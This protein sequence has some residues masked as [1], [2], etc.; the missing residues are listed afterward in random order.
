MRAGRD[1]GRLSALA[2]ALVATW[3][4]AAGATQV[5][6]AHGTSPAHRP[7]SDAAA[8]PLVT[9]APTTPSM[10]TAT[11]TS[12]GASTPAA[13]NDALGELG[14]MVPF[15]VA[16]TPA[17]ATRAAA[18]S[19]PALQ[20]TAGPTSPR[21]TAAPSHAATPTTKP[22]RKTKTQ[23]KP[24]P[25]S[26]T[27]PAPAPMNGVARVGSQLTLDGTPW[28]FTG[29]D[30]FGAT[31]YYS[32]NQ[33]CGSPVYDV[34]RM[35]T[36]LKPRSVV[37]VWAFQALAWNSKATPQHEDFG[38]IDRVVQA[39]DRHGVKLIMTLS[40][41][42]GTCDDG[43]WHDPAWYEGGYR[44]IRNDN[45]L[46]LEDR[47]FADYVTEIV[48][49]YRADPA[50]A[51]WEPVNEP[52]SSTCSGATGSGCFDS[53]KRSC[54]ANAGQILKGFY[55]AV[56]AQIRALE[57]GALISEGVAGGGQCG[58][59]SGQYD[60]VGN[61]DGVDL[62][63]YHDY[64]SEDQ[65]LPGGLADRIRQ[66]TTEIH[67]P[68]IVEEAGIGGGSS[69]CR[70]DTARASLVQAKVAALLSAGGVGWLPWWYA[71]S[72]SSCGEDFGPG[73]PLIAVLDSFGS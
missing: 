4:A 44:Q 43:A 50:I 3:V 65:A 42:S 25:A 30:A 46:G 54:P 57:P 62:L 22:K 15:G 45:G 33:G 11:P 21:S 48:T 72:P 26:T 5:A 35:L 18:T 58:T 56:G 9:P 53:S 17:P 27:T 64:G 73:D 8:L 49:R 7:A 1:G 67:K 29:F 52:E 38:A 31:T 55:D 13:V 47:S 14:E 41:Q 69:P 32:I 34:D 61:S 63:T 68:L 12:P 23:P 39:A 16:V 70:S 28:T 6:G 10:P 40:D 71:E 37:R 20:Q 2:V 59:V 66:A 24:A 60:E 51:F 36:S 19:A